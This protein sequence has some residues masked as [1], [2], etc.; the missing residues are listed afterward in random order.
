M[1]GKFSQK[2]F[3][4]QEEGY[5]YKSVPSR[6]FAELLKIYYKFPKDSE[7]ISID[8]MDI[9]LMLIRLM[10]NLNSMS[11]SSVRNKHLCM[12]MLVQLLEIM[13]LWCIVISC[14]MMLLQISYLKTNMVIWCC[15][16]T[17]QVVRYYSDLKDFNQSQKF[18]SKQV[19]DL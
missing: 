5:T 17:T 8:K 1:P 4:S 13:P 3:I 9:S 2:L 11:N 12:W 10:T 16:K 6:T 18:E 14:I 7:K 15:A 19:S